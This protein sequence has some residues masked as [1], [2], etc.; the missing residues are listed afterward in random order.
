MSSP[1]ANA[2]ALALKSSN[3]KTEATSATEKAAILGRQ[4]CIAAAIRAAPPNICVS[5]NSSAMR[6]SVHP[7]RTRPVSQ[8][9]LSA[10]DSTKP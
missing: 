3:P 4:Q 5:C 6:L 9:A 7:A 1:A 2:A 10:V 8:I